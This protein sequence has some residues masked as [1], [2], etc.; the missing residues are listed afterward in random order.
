[1]SKTQQTIQA[2]NVF[3]RNI[4]SDKKITVNRGGARSSKT[5]SQCQLIAIWLMTGKY[6]KDWECSHG[7]FS[8]VRKT[9]PALKSSVKRDFE[10]ILA[11]YGWLD[12]VKINKSELTYEYRGRMVDMFSVDNQQKVRGR[13][14]WGLFCNE[15]NELQYKTD[16]YQLFTRTEGPICIDFNP[17]D[18]ETWI[19]T[20]IEDRRAA[21]IGDVDVV[22]STYK[23]NRFL[24]DEMVRSIESLQ[25]DPEFWRAFG[26]G[27]YG[28]ISGQVFTNWSV[29]KWPSS[30][31]KRAYAMDFGFSNHPTAL[32]ECGISG[33]NLHARE[34]IYETGMLNSDIIDRLKYLEIRKS[35]E[36]YCDNAEP[37][38]IKEIEKAGFN[39]LP[40]K[41]P[42][43]KFGIDLLRR[44]HTVIDPQSVNMISEIK[45]Y[46]YKKINEFY[47]NEPID[48]FNH[49][50]DCLRYYAVEK[51]NSTGLI[52][53]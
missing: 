10:E 5:Y 25:S 40:C 26:L 11:E 34:L 39:A 13:K 21:E 3:Y 8:I 23:D 43:I 52:L 49:S 17:D 41:K 36:I 37:K 1:M 33:G 42:S 12:R 32:T 30:L 53:L 2:S 20:E 44:Y 24:S 28:V 35:D 15:A 48:A 38:T 22:I 4:L 27:E 51:L 31:K 29:G 14:R 50:M 16:F 46:K 6:K 9:L 47:T 45:R 18:P 7:V 19:K